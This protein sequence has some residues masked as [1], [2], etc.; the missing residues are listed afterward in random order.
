MSYL[1]R[2]FNP[3][4]QTGSYA[5]SVDAD[6]MARIQYTNKWYHP[7]FLSSLLDNI[8]MLFFWRFDSQ[9]PMIGKK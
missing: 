9:R 2:F 4:D 3:V 8:S 1:E 7:G 5:N 6:E